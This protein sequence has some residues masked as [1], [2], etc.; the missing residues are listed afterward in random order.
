M[1]QV[2]NE[3]RAELLASENPDISSINDEP[4]GHRV[5]IIYSRLGYFWPGAAKPH[6]PVGV[7]SLEPNDT[8]LEY[9]L[10]DRACFSKRKR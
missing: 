3:Y 9:S 10:R 5:D 8:S 2:S 1:M 6:L 7:R 4:Q